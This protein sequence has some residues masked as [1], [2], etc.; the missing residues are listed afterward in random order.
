MLQILLGVF[1][2]I[3]SVFSFVVNFCSTFVRNRV[4]GMIFGFGLNNYNQLGLTKKNSDTV[5][6]PQLTT[7]ENVKMITG[8]QHHTLVLTNDDKC[9]AIGRKDYGR[10]GL[11]DID[12][13]VDKLTPIAALDDGLHVS[14]L[15]CGECCSFA[16]TDDGKAYS[17]GM[18]SNQQLGVGSD[19]DQAA[20]ILLTGVQVRDKHVI[21]ISSGGQHTLFIAATPIESNQTNGVH[22][23]KKEEENKNENSQGETPKLNGK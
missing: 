8:G 20:P 9:Y 18:G 19:E 17:W 21:R 11:G 22:Q 10:L 4:N 5:F 2:V 12:T 16:I 1:V 3:V 14:Q 15:E 13:D 6:T 7:F 23:A